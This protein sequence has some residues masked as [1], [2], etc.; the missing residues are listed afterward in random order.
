MNYNRIV[1]PATGRFV[2]IN[3]TLGKKIINNYILKIGGSDTSVPDL[4]MNRTEKQCFNPRPGKSKCN[5]DKDNKVCY[6][7][8]S[9]KISKALIDASKKKKEVK[10]KKPKKK[11]PFTTKL[12]LGS[13]I[14][15]LGAT[16]A[17]Q[18][19]LNE[20]KAHDYCYP[21]KSGWSECPTNKVSLSHNSAISL[22][23]SN[24]YN[25]VE[26][27]EY[28]YTVDCKTGKVTI[29]D[30]DVSGISHHCLNDNQPVSAAGM[31]SRKGNK[32]IVDNCSGHFQPEAGGLN[33][34]HRILVNKNLVKEDGFFIVDNPYDSCGSDAQENV[35]T[36]QPL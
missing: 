36:L 24:L 30:E 8:K 15:P 9:R 16:Y 3:S 32:I 1:N 17:S 33:N 21:V 25:L 35:Y 11:I 13:L 23:L 12:A 20:I 31:I 6:S 27:D 26:G 5:W 2:N 19:N 29:V 14:L 7:G 28:M 10:K 34:I 4:C 22:T 18:M